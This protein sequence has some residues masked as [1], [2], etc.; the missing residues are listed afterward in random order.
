VLN[1]ISRLAPAV[2]GPETRKAAGKIRRLL[3]DYA[4][5]ED[6]ISVGAYKQGSNPRIDEAVAKREALEDFLIQ[7][8]SEKSSITETLTAMGGI[9]GVKI[10]EDEM[11]VL[12][13]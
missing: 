8:I 7:E 13:R 12:L 10:P 1:S 4:G 6:L 2:S 5:S 3:A 9:T 11:D